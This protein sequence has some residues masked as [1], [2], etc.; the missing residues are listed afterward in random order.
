MKEL[1]KYLDKRKS[2]RKIDKD[3]LLNENDLKQIKKFINDLVPLFDEFN[4]RCEL[5]KSDQTTSK[6]GEYNL[7]IYSTK[8]NSKNT[9]HL[10]N[11]GYMFE[12]LDLKLASINIGCCWLGLP[13][14]KS[15]YKNDEYIIMLGFSK[16]KEDDLRKSKDEF[17]RKKLS[18][19]WEGSFDEDV[20]YKASLAPSACNSQSWKVKVDNNILLVYRDKNIK[21]IIPRSFRS[22]FN[23]I[24]L[25]IYLCFLEI[26]LLMNN[27][28]FE[29]EIINDETDKESLILI[30]RYKIYE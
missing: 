30:A 12:Q 16:I 22:F 21:T 7:L 2:I 6:I 10:L 19:I 9:N 17:N 25:G 14:P 4:V 5:V 11:I 13:K 20:I 18:D 8:P 3:N 23:T 26:S 28:R 24:D 1:Y 27:I 15:N 29:R